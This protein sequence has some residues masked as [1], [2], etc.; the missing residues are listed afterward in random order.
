MQLRGLQPKHRTTGMIDEN[1]RLIVD[2]GD[3]N[4]CITRICRS[5]CGL[6]MY[7]I[8][9]SRSDDHACSCEKRIIQAWN[10][11]KSGTY[12]KVYS[13]PPHPEDTQALSVALACNSCHYNF[14]WLIGCMV[15]G[16]SVWTLL[17]IV[18][19]LAPIDGAL[20]GWCSR[21]SFWCWAS[22]GERERVIVRILFFPVLP[23]REWHW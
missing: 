4:M 18:W 15:S 19:S 7:M 20:H 2:L 13:R 23:S 5:L 6:R 14:V 8:S 3:I 12:A 22:Q 21:R 1:E 17:P 9:R 10:K 11:R 16:A